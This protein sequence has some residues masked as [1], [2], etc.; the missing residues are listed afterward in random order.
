[1]LFLAEARAGPLLGQDHLLHQR[2]HPHHR[3]LRVV[4]QIQ[5]WRKKRWSLLNLNICSGTSCWQKLKIEKDRNILTNTKWKTF[6]QVYFWKRIENPATPASFY[7]LSV[8][9]TQLNLY[10]TNK[11]K[12]LFPVIL[13]KIMQIVANF[14]CN[15]CQPPS[16]VSVQSAWA[17]WRS[18]PGQ[19][20]PGVTGAGSG[21]SCVA[22]SQPRGARRWSGGSGRSTPDTWTSTSTTRRRTSTRTPSGENHRVL[23][24]RC[25]TFEEHV[26]L[27]ILCVWLFQQKYLNP[28]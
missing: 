13:Q 16:L 15:F 23:R 9:A 19:E 8:Y 6:P 12:S 1:M 18:W 20:Y 26:C 25:I 4:L 10:S 28:V 24:W 14:F 22:T 11:I 5:T 7:F 2:L 3:P 21:R 17:S 27:V